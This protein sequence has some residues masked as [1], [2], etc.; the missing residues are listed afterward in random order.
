M[1]KTLIFRFAGFLRTQ[2]RKE[3][4]VRSA[5]LTL[6]EME[7]PAASKKPALPEGDALEKGKK[8]LK[9]PGIIFSGLKPGLTNGDVLERIKAQSR[10]SEQK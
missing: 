1:V 7:K 5:A 10:N 4:P 2:V 3:Q 9:Q 6:G 8:P